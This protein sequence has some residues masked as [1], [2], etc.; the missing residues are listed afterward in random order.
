MTKAQRTIVDALSEWA[1]GAEEDGSP[2]TLVDVLSR[3]GDDGSCLLEL[4]Y[5]SGP[6][7]EITLPGPDGF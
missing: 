7:E 1:G 3:E 5:A 2:S 4:C 6:N